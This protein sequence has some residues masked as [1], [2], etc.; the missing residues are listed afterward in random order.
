VILPVDPAK[1]AAYAS[2]TLLMCAAP[3]PACLF[4]LTTGAQRGR[5][6]LVGAVTGLNLGNICWFLAAGLGLGALEAAF[7]LA[8][9]ILAYGG[10]A[11][12]A[13]LGL[14]ALIAAWR[15][16]AVALHGP[17]LGNGSAL[18]Q[19]FIVQMSNPKALLFITAILPPFMDANRPVAPQLLVLSATAIAMDIACMSAYGLGGAALAA[20]MSEPRFHRVFSTV[21]GVVLV[22]AAVM[23]ARNGHA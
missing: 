14:R 17:R 19:G 22:C 15:G 16:E 13:W 4:T 20:R 10:A 8:F 21:V 23:I 6:G 3:G 12:V 1:Y 2:I 7:P 9:R 18:R 5:A 11:Y